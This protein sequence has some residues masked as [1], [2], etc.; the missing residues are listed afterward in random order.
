MLSI[1]NYLPKCAQLTH[2]LVHII[3]LL[4]LCC[5]GGENIKALVSGQFQVH[6]TILLP[7]VITLLIRFPDLINSYL[8]LCTLRTSTSEF[9]ETLSPWKCQGPFPLYFILGALCLN[10]LHFNLYSI[11][12][13]E[14]TEICF[15]FSSCRHPIFPTLFIKRS[16][17]SPLSILGSLVKQV[18][19]TYARACIWPLVSVPLVYMFVFTQVPN[20]Y[21]QYT[22]IYSLRYQYSRNVSFSTHL[23]IHL[24]T[25]SC[26]WYPVGKYILCPSTC[27]GSAEHIG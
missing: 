18:L 16:V 13:C 5:C 14:G 8:R 6:N 4:L 22:R 10:V 11:Q 17:F 23:F 1:V 25:Y 2:L 19:T 15:S 21:Q 27:L 3:S 7:V 24:L 12:H 9:P 26:I 20:Y